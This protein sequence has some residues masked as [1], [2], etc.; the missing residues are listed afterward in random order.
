MKTVTAD[1]ILLRARAALSLPI[2]YQLG[3][4][5]RNPTAATPAD[6]AGKLDCSGFVAWCLGMPRLTDDPFYLDFAGGWMNTDGIVADTKDARG[7][8]NKVPDGH[9]KPA[10]LLVFGKGPGRSYGHVGIVSRVIHGK[11]IAVIHCSAAN[12]PNAVAETIPDVFFRH[13]AI[14]ARHK[15]LVD[16]SPTPLMP[17]IASSVSLTWRGRM[18]VFGGPADMGVGAGEGLALRGGGDVS[19]PRLGA[20]FL[21]KQPAGTSGL[22]RRLNPDSYYIACRWDYGITPRSFLRMITVT[23]CN[24]R[25][26]KKLEAIPVDW[27]PNNRT[28]RIADLS[29]GLARALELKTDDECIVTVPVPE[30]KNDPF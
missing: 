19:H 20:V 23:V 29:P 9:A 14:I 1:A 4:G 5:G 24:P 11:P 28:G 16:E 30:K 15:G 17:A 13:G 25:T 6:G 3:A 26:G 18:S 21:T 22:A 7:L 10:D 8:F 12:K 2:A 27:G